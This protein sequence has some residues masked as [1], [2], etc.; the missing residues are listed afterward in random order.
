MRR[1]RPLS[2]FYAAREEETAASFETASRNNNNNNSSEG[3]F[4]DST[5]PLS[6]RKFFTWSGNEVESSDSR[7]SSR[8]DRKRNIHSS[9]IDCSPIPFYTEP[10]SSLV[11]PPTSS[12]AVSSPKAFY[13]GPS[14]QD[15]IPALLQQLRKSSSSSPA[16]VREAALRKPEQRSRCIAARPAAVSERSLSEADK[17]NLSTELT[18]DTAIASQSIVVP[19]QNKARQATLT[20]KASAAFRDSGAGNETRLRRSNV[21]I[22]C[23]VRQASSESVAERLIGSH[24][25]INSTSP[26]HAGQRGGMRY[27][28]VQ[29]PAAVHVAAYVPPPSSHLPDDDTASFTSGA[30]LS[31]SESQANTS[32]LPRENSSTGN[33][34]SVS[35]DKSSRRG[36]SDSVSS[37][38]EGSHDLHNMR[39]LYRQPQSQQQDP[40]RDAQAPMKSD[41]AEAPN[42]SR[43]LTNK[44]IAPPVQAPPARVVDRG[45]IKESDSTA[46]STH[47][48]IANSATTLSSST[49]VSPSCMRD[50][51][52]S[53]LDKPTTRKTN[54][55]RTDSVRAHESMLSSDVNSTSQPQCAAVT[56]CPSTHSRHTS[57]RTRI[58]ASPLASVPAPR[59]AVVVG[60]VESRAA[61]P[62]TAQ[63]THRKQAKVKS[64]YSTAPIPS[65]PF[66][67]AVLEGGDPLV[68]RHTIHYL[69]AKARRLE[70]E[71]VVLWRQTHSWNPQRSLAPQD[72]A[73]AAAPISPLPF[74]P[75]RR[76]AAAVGPSRPTRKS[77]S[78]GAPPA[79]MVAAAGS[80]ATTSQTEAM[81]TVQRQETSSSPRVFVQRQRRSAAAGRSTTASSASSSRPSPLPSPSV[82]ATSTPSRSPRST[83]GDISEGVGNTPLAAV[84]HSVT[85]SSPSAVADTTTATQTRSEASVTRPATT[86][87]A[88]MRTKANSFTTPLTQVNASTQSSPPGHRL[89]RE[90]QTVQRAEAAVQ[91]QRVSR[92]AGMTADFASQSPSTGISAVE[93]VVSGERVSALPSPTVAVATGKA[94]R[95]G[96]VKSLQSSVLRTPM[97]RSVHLGEPVEK[98][99]DIFAVTPLASTVR[100]H[101]SV[102]SRRSM[103]SITSHATPL[104]VSAL[105][106][107]PH[108]H[109]S[110]S[111][112]HHYQHQHPKSSVDERA[113]TAMNTTALNA[114]F[115]SLG[116][117]STYNKQVQTASILSPAAED[118]SD[119]ET[120]LDSNIDGGATTA[121]AER[122]SIIE[123]HTSAAYNRNTVRRLRAYCSSLESARQ[124]LRRLA[125]T[126]F[127]NS[128]AAAVAGSRGF[129]SSSRSS[130][131]SNFPLPLARTSAPFERAAA[132]AATSASSQLS[133]PIFRSEYADPEV[134]ATLHDVEETPAMETMIVLQ[135]DGS[136]T[137]TKRVVDGSPSRV[138][139]SAG[140][141]PSHTTHLHHHHQQQQ[142]QQGNTTTSSFA[143][144][145]GWEGEENVSPSL[146]SSLRPSP[147]AH[148]SPFFFPR[149]GVRRDNQRDSANSHRGNDGVSSPFNTSLRSDSNMKDVIPN[150]HLGPS[151]RSDSA[152]S[153]PA[154]EQKDGARSPDIVPFSQTSTSSLPV[155]T[156]GHRG[157]FAPPSAVPAHAKEEVDEVLFKMASAAPAQSL[158]HPPLPLAHNAERRA[159]SV[160]STSAAGEARFMPPAD[161]QA[162]R[163]RSGS[164]NSHRFAVPGVRPRDGAEVRERGSN[165]SRSSS[166]SRAGMENK[167]GSTPVS[168]AAKAT[169][170]TPPS[171]SRLSASASAA[172]AV[173][174]CDQ[175]AAT[176]AAVVAVPT[177]PRS[178]EQTSSTKSVELRSSDSSAAANA[179]KVV[180]N[181]LV[182]TSPPHLPP[183][184]V[185]SRLTTATSPSSSQ[186]IAEHDAADIKTPKELTATLAAPSYAS[187]FASMPN[188]LVA[189]AEEGGNLCNSR[190]SNNSDLGS[191]LPH[192]PQGGMANLGKRSSTAE[193][194]DKVI[195]QKGSPLHEMVR[196]RNVTVSPPSTDTE[197]MVDNNDGRS[198]EGDA[199]VHEAVADCFSDSEV[200]EADELLIPEPMPID[201]DPIGGDVERAPKMAHL[202]SP[203]PPRAS[204]SS[205]SGK[206][207]GREEEN[208]QNYVEIDGPEG[209][210][211]VSVTSSRPCTM[212][213]MQRPPVAPSRVIV[214]G[215]NSSPSSSLSRSL[216]SFSSASSDAG[217][218][219]GVDSEDDDED[220]VLQAG[221]L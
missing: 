42:T 105:Q 193:F 24:D 67:E 204:S 6:T 49:H 137:V 59:P 219:N 64:F 135:E 22:P 38:S 108:P 70:E 184:P 39:K 202:I 140:R 196:A 79:R 159:T 197:K 21:T 85:V 129:A 220:E 201:H 185:A 107:P 166:S 151:L 29:Q 188:T 207:T 62:A 217:R 57:R 26:E 87:T 186:L 71:N 187:A 4:R 77:V 206:V 221:W 124:Q 30:E 123:L 180:L 10:S 200:E 130:S 169:L 74:R 213:P 65:A 40:R 155:D 53:I 138:S 101:H 132:A 84:H 181:T 27:V 16:L 110:S 131:R 118:D 149:A 170:A 14:M 37:H 34:R 141:S 147:H 210:S 68:L 150:V 3:S 69:L 92:G 211:D 66:A 114:S 48:S 215:Q 5:H 136:G 162:T 91:H 17:K 23:E 152:A 9:Q 54:S 103:G 154:S 125:A 111:G 116:R 109:T 189:V 7:T 12:G 102:E 174:S 63:P 171:P 75:R 190:E 95:V 2:T 86:T 161:A 142:Q 158:S 133:R 35:R 156:V 99:D 20:A 15:G 128:C 177:T 178:P 144:Y 208:D 183:P 31:A 112:S 191:P 88:G 127:P 139:A 81:E 145:S 73:I 218:T 106:T 179:V 199:F 117:P 98:P 97:Q 143:S 25:T 90:V 45:G 100:S 205:E 173:T 78:T 32:T 175:R 192:A 61:S 80:A 96:N 36:N 72:D 113:S 115:S 203:S 134:D 172:A 119:G 120:A 19:P 11:V 148:R 28:V 13:D 94:A 209:A 46:P 18:A 176:S 1:H 214:L 47:S 126:S 58:A 50:L 163:T 93:A 83:D 43:S 56:P 153:W 146:L 212:P 164:V 121:S 182:V 33:C 122:T 195:Q 44:A 41:T 165:S 157:R 216:H 167:A 82:P 55:S 168:V 194:V 76:A 198:I 60:A 8:E 52:A 89:H 104:Y 51:F 160:P